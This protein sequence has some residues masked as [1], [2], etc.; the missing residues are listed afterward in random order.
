ME[1]LP[2]AARP[3]LLP[4]LAGCPPTSASLTY[5]SS[6][7]REMLKL[8]VFLFLLS[9]CVCVCVCGVCVLLVWKDLAHHSS[10]DHHLSAEL[11]IQRVHSELLVLCI[12][13]P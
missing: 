6:L 12:Y 10:M 2:C 7:N 1:I 11:R 5:I 9:V 3:V 8:I 4:A 13:K